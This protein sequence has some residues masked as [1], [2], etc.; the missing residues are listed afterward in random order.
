MND[1]IE[2]EDSGLTYSSFKLTK[3]SLEP[4]G[5]PNFND[6]LK[7]GEFLKNT[8]G[9]VHFWIGDWL[10]YGEKTY[11]ETYTQAIDE[12]GYE[13]STLSNDK[14]VASKVG[15][16]LR[17]E[18]LSFGHHMAVADLSP[19]EQSE[20]LEMAER[21]QLT[22]NDFKKEVRKYKLKLDLPEFSD[23]DFAPSKEDFE[24]ITGIVM[25]LVDVTDRISDLKMD[26]INPDARDFLL[27]QLR[28]SGG[29]FVGLVSKYGK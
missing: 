11:G 26:K 4:V 8:N 2:Y 6:W 10:R 20:M 29:K 15:S 18:N 7:C 25:D 27:S 14:W 22:L 24:A 9:A 5:N 13:Y 28:K 3:N 1:L 16:S 23:D 17:K 19:E 21:D 12:T